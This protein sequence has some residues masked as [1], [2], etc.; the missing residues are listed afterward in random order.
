VQSAGRIVSKGRPWTS[1]D[2]AELRRLLAAG[3]AV[4]EI[5]RQIG[6]STWALYARARQ[7]GVRVGP[8]PWTPEEV[9][10][11]RAVCGRLSQRQVAALI[12]KSRYQ[13]HRLAATDEELYWPPQPHTGAPY[14]RA[15]DEWLREGLRRGQDWIDISMTVGRPPESVRLRAERLGIQPGG[16]GEKAAKSLTA[17]SPKTG[18]TAQ[19]WGQ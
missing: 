14:T 16:G 1:E 17:K 6:R 3:T 15:E 12:G 2:V 5:A 4:P 9:I 8:A 11:V 18:S 7:D 10:R 19:E 13:V